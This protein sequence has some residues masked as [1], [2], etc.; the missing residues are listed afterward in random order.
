MESH[1]DFKARATAAIIF[2]TETTGLPPWHR[3][4]QRLSDWGG[5]RM[6]QFAWMLIDTNGNETSTYNALIRPQFTIPAKATEIHGISQERALADGRDIEEVLHAFQ[7]TLERNP[8]ATLVAHNIEFDLSILITEAKRLEM[9]RLLSLLTGMP[10]H[11]TMLTAVLGTKRRW[12]R[13]GVL[14]KELYGVDAEGTAHDAMWDVKTCV[15]I[16]KK[17]CYSS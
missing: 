16:Y 5:C 3:D 1:Q 14:Y 17:Q 7:I 11:C 10:R 9:T 8:N 4:P 15:E 2:D 13:L 12:P 6:V